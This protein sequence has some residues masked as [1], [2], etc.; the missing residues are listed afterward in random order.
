MKRAATIRN[1]TGRSIAIALLIGGILNVP[2]TAIADEGGVSF[3]LPGL[4]GSLAATPLQP[5]WSFATIYYHGSVSASGSAAASREITIGGLPTT[6]TASLDVNLHSN[7][8]IFLLTPSYVFATPVLGGQLSLGMMAIAGRPPT[9]LDGTL[10]L[11][12]DQGHVFQK[13]GTIDSS[14]TGFGDLYPSA[15][16][17]WNMG[18][19][20]FMTYV[21]GDIPVGAYDP[22]RLANLGIGHGAVDGGFGYT[23]YNPQTGLEFSAVTGLTYNFENPDTNYRNGVDWHLDWGASKS[24]SKQLFVGAVGYVYHQLTADSGAAAFLGDNISRVAGIGPQVGYIFPV[25][26]KQG[27]L[28]LKGYYEFDADRR[29]DGWNVWLTFAISPAAPTPTA[30]TRR[31]ITK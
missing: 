16:L 26:D 28:N 4:F 14:L 6:V 24:L 31:M 13:A 9:S 23:Y 27:Y 15:N 25:G 21:T 1:I 7:P 22:N 3:W 20:N 18:V 10:T 5:G 17:R 11:K 12:D 19:H 30:P 8:D 29:A 2:R